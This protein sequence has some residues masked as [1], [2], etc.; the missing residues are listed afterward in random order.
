MAEK[1]LDDVKE[2]ES[3][4]PH[5]DN[6]ELPEK[7]RQLLKDELRQGYSID[8][9]EKKTKVADE[10]A[11]D[12]V[13][14]MRKSGYKDEDIA[15]ELR[16]NNYK[17]EDIDRMLASARHH[18]K[19]PAKKQQKKEAETYRITF[20]E[21]IFMFLYT[22]FMVF[23][24]GWINV[25]TGAELSVIFAS[26]IPTFATILISLAFFSSGQ[27]KYKIIVW[28]VPIFTVI[29]WYA[30]AVSG[31]VAA[32]AKVDSGNISVFNF[33]LSMIYLIVLDAFRSIELN[34]IEPL[35]KRIKTT[36]EKVTNLKA[37]KLEEKVKT[38]GTEKSVEEYIQAIEDKS[39]ALNFVIGRVYSAKHGGSEKLRNMIRIDK[40]WYNTFAEIRPDEIKSNILRLRKAVY[41]IGERLNVLHLTEKE[42]FP[43]SLS[44]LK[45]LQRNPEG[46]DRIIDVLIAND[47][48]PVY[49]Y[50][51]SAVEF[52]NKAAKEID[53]LEQRKKKR[54]EILDP[55]LQGQKN[56][57]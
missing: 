20:N 23:L 47:K 43:Q 48:D 27:Y 51:K 33:L 11:Y 7:E 16:R 13:E 8:L 44:K 54:S 24:I 1:M 40:E 18:Y 5:T 4:L 32:L 14:R 50:Y 9:S 38:Y 17:K 22:L 35:K 53:A 2:D 34:V 10:K 6:D 12:Y 39:K 3:P 46:K 52:C 21:K 41:S 42:V 30:I 31:Q 37:S 28:L 49:A 29:I 45:K 55:N 56:Q 25:R 36:E 19:L 57:S 26:F 15:E